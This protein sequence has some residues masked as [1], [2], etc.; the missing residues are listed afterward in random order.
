ME[1]YSLSVEDRIKEVYSKFNISDFF[2]WWQGDS[3]KYM[4]V[5]IMDYNLIKEVAN[6][7]NISYSKSGVYVNNAVQL[8][9]VIAYC[10]ER[11]VM[12]WGCNSRKRNWDIW[13]YKS[14]GGGNYYID[15]VDTLFIDIDRCVK[16]GP[17]TNEDL[18]RANILADKIL[19]R[20]G[21]QGWDK[22]YCKICTGN[23]VQLV[24]KLDYPIKIPN[25][26]YD[27]EK[28]IFIETAEYQKII[29]LLRKGVG[30]QILK[31]NNKLKKDLGVEIDK[32]CFKIACVCSLPFTKNFKYGGFTWRGIVEIKQDG[33]N[34]G[35]S[36]YIINYQDKEYVEKKIF[37]NTN[38]QLN[39]IHIIKKGKLM[40]HKLVRFMLDNNLPH[41][42]I[43]NTL[44]FMLKCLLRDSKF[45]L[46]SEEFRLFHKQLE[47]KYKDNFP[48]NLPDVKYQFSEDTIN[49]YCIN[50]F[51]PPPY[52]VLSQR[53][54]RLNMKIE[55]LQ[56]SW[57]LQAK[58]NI[59]LPD[60]TIIQDDLKIF[61]SQLKE[62]DYQNINKVANFIKAC[63]K[64]YG[65]KE[66][67]YFCK[68]IMYRYLGYD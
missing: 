58:E 66:T 4:E 30:P 3:G 42:A 64:K 15:C 52:I 65:E 32:T 29:E 25:L 34:D 6:K 46:Q 50:N 35:L 7:L 36:D 14:F 44:F 8:K 63:I 61:K 54:K 13:G 23:G 28:K 2:K 11:A 22:N 38:K 26:E 47:Q 59:I 48:L 21:T 1:W 55:D 39:N 33:V 49:N 40:E 20:L 19:E 27:N 56:Y 45:D 9:N 10:R 43:N 37:V 68:Y 17:A 31:L 60:D 53:F 62:G 51:I 24:I 12:W 5:R 67:E 41:G 57:H 18:E 16:E